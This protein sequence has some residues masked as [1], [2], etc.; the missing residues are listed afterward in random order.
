MSP[1]FTRVAIASDNR[2]FATGLGQALSGH[3]DVIVSLCDP[4]HESSLAHMAAS[5]DV[6]L[7]D[8]LATGEWPRLGTIPDAAVV[9][10]VGA[11]DNDAWAS[12][13]LSAGARGILTRT[14]MPEDVVGAV[15]VVHDG[16]IWARRRWLNDCV[17][18]AVCDARRRLA[19]RDVV[20]A[21]L[22]R[23]EREVLRHAATGI[24][25]KELAA[26][27]DI[28]AATV[29]VHLTRIFQKLGIGSRAA[30]AAAYHDDDGGG[31]S[32]DVPRKLTVASTR[33][34]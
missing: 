29:K 6:I 32:Y 28:S 10:F 23:R 13:A 8:A 34:L 7:L 19:A 24:S 33:R 22:S 30:L 9:I 2:L 20:D 27:L 5:Y 15:R 31:R 26:R 3:S 12:A 14:A 4:A 1:S 16:G 17:R 11:P 25:N 18:H 21:H